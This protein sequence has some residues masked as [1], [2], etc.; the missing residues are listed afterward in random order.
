M[1][2]FQISTL[3]SKD[4]NCFD[5]ALTLCS[6]FPRGKERIRDQFKTEISRLK[7]YYLFSQGKYDNAIKYLHKGAIPIRRVLSLYPFL[8]PE[9]LPLNMSVMVPSLNCSSPYP[10]RVFASTYEENSA[11]EALMPLLNSR[12]QELLIKLNQLETLSKGSN[13][14][15]INGTPENYSSMIQFTMDSEDEVSVRNDLQLIDY[16]QNRLDFKNLGSATS[17]YPY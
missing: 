17:I 1:L 9:D 11:V 4:Y 2:H 5:D 7:G 10:Q 12:R 16:V 13:G 6:L 8:V 3:I 15:T 14:E